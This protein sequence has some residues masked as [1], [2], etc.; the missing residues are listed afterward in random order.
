LEEHK[1]KESFQEPGMTEDDIDLIETI[2]EKLK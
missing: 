2:I 1:N